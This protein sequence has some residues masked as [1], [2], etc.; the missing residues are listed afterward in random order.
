[1]M[2]MMMMFLQGAARVQA[3][4][5]VV[6]EP[7]VQACTKCKLAQ[8]ASLISTGARVKRTHH[9]LDQVHL[10]TSSGAGARTHPQ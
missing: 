2:M 8:S 3:P 9:T 1:M 6:S 7:S 4:A 10:D 5:N